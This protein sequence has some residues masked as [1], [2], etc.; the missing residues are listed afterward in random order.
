MID[1]IDFQVHAL[2]SLLPY[3]STATVRVDAAVSDYVTH[4][5]R[6]ESM[7]VDL[8]NRTVPWTGWPT[9][10]NQE[11]IVSVSHLSPYECNR[12]HEASGC[13]ADQRYVMH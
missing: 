8:H 4:H 1:W 9:D 13:R 10:G 5:L 6:P 2:V 12:R 3:T 11:W 7:Q